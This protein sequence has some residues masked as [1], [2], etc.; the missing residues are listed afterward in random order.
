MEG[1][2]ARLVLSLGG[3]LALSS[4]AAIYGVANASSSN[5]TSVAV[6]AQSSGTSNQILAQR[7]VRS[8]PNGPPIGSPIVVATGNVSAPSV[9]MDAKGDFVVTWTQVVKLGKDISSEIEACRFKPGGAPAGAEF[10]VITGHQPST[11]SHVAEDS[12]GDF[13]V[14]YTIHSAITGYDIQASLFNSSGKSI[15]SIVV[16]NSH[17]D[18]TTSSVAMGPGGKFDIA[19]D[20]AHKS[21]DH[22]VELVRYSNTGAV[23]GNV[24]VA[25]GA[26]SATTPSVAVDNYGAAVIAYRAH[27]SVQDYIGARRMTTNGKIGT[28]ITI[29]SYT[30]ALTPAVALARTGGSFVVAYITEPTPSG[31]MAIP[32]VWTTEVNAQNKLGATTSAGSARFV[33]GISIDASNHYLVTYQS[34]YGPISKS[35]ARFGSLP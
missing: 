14:S 28:P 35:F 10:T 31:D 3:E 25:G 11:D 32:T 8:D 21:T 20:L 26:A 1:L 34:Q 16:A 9:A 33:P 6:W 29:A 13:V 27:T 30:V 5:N 15:V 18:E 23:L 12:A 7:L 24:L 19:Y 22:D 17:L 4:P 2:E